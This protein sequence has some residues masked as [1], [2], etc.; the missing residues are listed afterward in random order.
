MVDMTIGLSHGSSDK[1]ISA[2]ISADLNYSS[3][4]ILPES[5][6]TIRPLMTV[7]TAACDHPSRT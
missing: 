6:N 2:R 5:F 7:R 4:T 3:R 1:A